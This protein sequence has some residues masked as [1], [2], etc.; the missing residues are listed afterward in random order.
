M[1][2]IYA[3][4]VIWSDNSVLKDLSINLCDFRAGTEVIN[5]V[6]TQDYIYVG[7]LLPFNHKYI[8]VSV[9]NTNSATLSVDIWWNNSWTPAVDLF[10]GTSVAGTPLSQSGIIRWNTHI[11]RGWDCVQRSSDV[12]GL[13][14]TEIYNMYWVRFKYSSNL[15]S[16]TALAFVGQKFSNDDQ[17]YSFYSDLQNSTIKTA[18]EAGKTTWTEQHY[19]AAEYIIKDLRSRNMIYSADQV[20]EPEMLEEAAIHKTAEIIY[21]GMGAEFDRDKTE[22]YKSYMSCMGTKF[23]NIDKN[24]DGSVSPLERSTRSLYATR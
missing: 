11:E 3:Q 17:L 19:M 1:G 12:D 10:D 20:F 16:S 23:F 6:S 7:S 18:Y 4:R 22:A 8:D 2:N 21:R 9:T 14:G 15:L 13:S 5:F 24:K